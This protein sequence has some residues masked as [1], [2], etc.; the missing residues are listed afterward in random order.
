MNHG[1]NNM[2]RKDVL[3]GAGFGSRIAEDEGDHLHSYFV[4]TD[5]WR[6][7]LSGEVDIVFG[8]KGAGKSALYSLLVAKK[9]ELRL[10]RRTLFLAA[11][12]PRGTPAFR[13][14]TAEPP[15]SEEQFRGLWKLYFLS[16]AADYLRHQLTSQNMKNAAALSV[17]HVLT[18][19]GL[20][21]PGVTLLSRL[22]AAL[23]YMRRFIPHVE[24][25]VTDPHSGLTFT[26]KITLGEPTSEQRGA[27]YR[28]L[29]DLLSQL[30]LGFQQV[31][32]TVWLVLDRLDVAFAESDALEG[33][34]LRALFRTYLDTLALSHIK[35]KIFLR[36]DIWN[37]IVAGGFRE[38]S[39]V[40]RSLTLSWSQQSLLNLIVRRILS[41]EAVCTYYGVNRI[42]VLA[43]AE[44]QREFF[45]K[46]FP[47]QIDIGKNRPRTLDWMLSRTADGSKRTTPRELIHLLLAAREE[48]LKL[49]ELGNSEPED[50]LLIGKT[51]IRLALPAVSKA[52]YE[53]TLCAENPG[54]QP[55]LHKLE[56]E[57]AQQSLVSLAALWNCPVEKSSEI[58]E[59]LVEAGFFER[60]GAK[61][62]P[63]FWVPMLYRD[64]LDLVQGAA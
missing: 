27:G 29:D 3:A 38:A 21:A 28:S 62:A 2:I 32:I 43:T 5:Q 7:L 8:A 6:R 56:R 45:Y 17:I 51:A 9:D 36:D 39:H 52:R 50:N 54:L 58:A 23:G 25:G 26:G 34:A 14:L 30:N 18:E 20:L 53:Q 13:D 12:N 55:F 24:G 22:R 44:L 61:D 10:G 57:K 42:E 31:N 59:K 1:N 49:T 41:N 47:E 11:E 64:A 63:I 15:L 48:Q 16:I 19:H 60:R 33:N 46:V 37:K 35:T 4:E 40:T